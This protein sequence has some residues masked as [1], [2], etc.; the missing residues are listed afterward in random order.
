M[1]VEFKAGFTDLA[2]GPVGW[3]R[4]VGRCLVRVSVE[5]VRA[6]LGACPFD[7]SR[8]RVQVLLP[9]AR[10]SPACAMQRRLMMAHLA[11]GHD[12]NLY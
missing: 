1:Q 5:G 4:H 9:F 12:V 2:E 7:P 11:S 10:W 8:K 6:V 3:Q